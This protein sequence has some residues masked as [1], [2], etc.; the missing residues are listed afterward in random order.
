MSAQI[1]QFKVFED[2]AASIL[3]R[4][5]GAAGALITQ[6]SLSSID[7]R[8]YDDDDDSIV[9]FLTPP[10]VIATCVSDTLLTTANFWTVDTTGY[11][12][13]HD[14]PAGSLPEGDHVYRLEYTFTPTSG[15]PYTQPI[16]LTTLNIRSTIPRWP[17]PS[18]IPV[19][20]VVAQADYD[21][22][23]AKVAGLVGSTGIITQQNP[24]ATLY[25]ASTA[26][27]YA[28]YSTR[29]WFIQVSASEGTQ[30][31][32]LT[33]R[34]RGLVD[35]LQITPKYV[36]ILTEA[37]TA[38]AG[39][40]LTGAN[41]NRLYGAYELVKSKWPNCIAGVSISYETLKLDGT[42]ATKIAACARFDALMLTSYPAKAT[43]AYVPSDVTKAHYQA[44]RNLW[45]KPLIMAEFG[46]G[47]D[48]TG[49]DA[50]AMVALDNAIDAAA[51]LDFDLFVWSFSHDA[52]WWTNAAFRQHGLLTAAGIEKPAWDRMERMVTDYAAQQE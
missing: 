44:A 46:W 19:P 35:N 34:M 12:F 17:R 6:A 25:D 39:N 11:N 32:Y 26:A 4:V 18:C 10:I 51:A 50:A 3:M 7:C 41:V 16:Q 47:T 23:W 22:A 42:L 36:N 33:T 21:T 2:G 20:P 15:A 30:S 9:P 43:P 38:A 31:D 28:T 48:D 45:S 37:E 40:L 49:G 8:I 27:K 29:D 1:Y 52:A 14:L 13:R 5:R 24:C